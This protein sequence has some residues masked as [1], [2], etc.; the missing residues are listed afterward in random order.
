MYSVTF[1]PWTHHAAAD[2]PA[3]LL[4]RQPEFPG[5]PRVHAELQAERHVSCPGETQGPDPG[6]THRHPD[7]REDGVATGLR[8]L[9]PG[10][11]TL[12]GGGLALGLLVLRKTW[13]PTAWSQ[14]HPGCRHTGSG[15][16]SLSMVALLTTF[17]STFHI[18]T[19]NRKQSVRDVSLSAVPSEAQRFLFLP[20]GFI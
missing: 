20:F 9:G 18:H 17:L 10:M 6:V 7:R 8:V 16:F 14:R 5:L 1:C 2:P 4:E 13:C 15:W 3:L 19:H 12:E 11:E